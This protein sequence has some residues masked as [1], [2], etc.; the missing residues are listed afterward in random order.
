MKWISGNPLTMKTRGFQVP[1]I[2]W[3]APPPGGAIDNQAKGAHSH[4]Y[5]GRSFDRQAHPSRTGRVADYLHADCTALFVHQTPELSQ[6]PAEERQA[7]EKA[8]SLRPGVCRSKRGF[9]GGSDIAKTVVE[10]ARPQSSYANFLWRI[11]RAVFS[12]AL[13]GK[14]FH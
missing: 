6:L 14:E 7:V 1:R 3:R 9:L 8:P 2:F 12:N 4:P 5:H 13:R 11:R 10:F